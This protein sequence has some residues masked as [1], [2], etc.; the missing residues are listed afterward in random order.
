MTKHSEYERLLEE[1]K[2]EMAVLN[3]RVRKDIIEYLLR[4]YVDDGVHPNVIESAYNEAMKQM[5][6]SEEEARARLG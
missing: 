6:K 1:A 4:W 5:R 2:R 3:E